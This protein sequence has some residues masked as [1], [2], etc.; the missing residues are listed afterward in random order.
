MLRSYASEAQELMHAGQGLMRCSYG[1]GLAWLCSASWSFLS[2][3]E[4]I[5]GQYRLTFMCPGVP[6]ADQKFEEVKDLR[7]ST[8]MDSS[9]LDCQIAGKGGP[10]LLLVRRSDLRPLRRRPS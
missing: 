7:R 10:F 6:L 8:E 5:R 1:Q 3:L 9:F 4:P 2:H